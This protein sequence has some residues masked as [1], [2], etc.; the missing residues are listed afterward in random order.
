MLFAEEP[1]IPDYLPV[2]E[3][4]DC[5][6]ED[7]YGTSKHCSE[8]IAKAVAR[9][10]GVPVTTVRPASIFGPEAYRAR[11]QHE[12]FDLSKTGLSGDFWSYVDVRDVARIVEAAL[13]AD[14]DGHETYLCAADENY[15]GHSTTEL[16]EA[17]GHDLPEECTLEGTQAA[18]SNRK[19]A[20]RLGWTPRYS[21]RNVDDPAASGPEWC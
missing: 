21:W 3:A 5:R 14:S 20:E 8:E 4:H 7:P 17:T 15:L 19:A 1:W 18:F 11:P 16:V 10:H 13:A 12:G 2:D 6:P 9:R